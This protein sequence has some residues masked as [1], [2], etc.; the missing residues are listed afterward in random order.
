MGLSPWGSRIWLAIVL[1]MLGA[2][3]IGWI[4]GWH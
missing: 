4:P 3:W 2:L 1:T